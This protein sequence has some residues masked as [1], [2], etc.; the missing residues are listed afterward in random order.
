MKNWH[1]NG[2]QDIAAGAAN[3]DAGRSVK[4]E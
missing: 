4:R 3:P 1:N 2:I